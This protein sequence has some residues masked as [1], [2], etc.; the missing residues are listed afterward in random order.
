MGTYTKPIV[1]RTPPERSDRVKD[2]QWLM[3]GNNRFKIRTYFGAID[4]IAGP[5]TL[6]AAKTMK[7]KIGYP[8]SEL[9][10][11]F[12]QTL[13][14]YLRTDGN[15]KLRSA[16]MVTRAKARQVT[17][18]QR[19][20]P[21]T[22]YRRRIIGYPGQGTHSYSQPPH[23]WQ[24]DRAYDLAVPVG[25]PVVA[26]EAGR[27]GPRIGDLNSWNPRL[28]GKRLTVENSLNAIYYAHLSQLAVVA[29]QTVKVGQLLGYSGTANGVAHLHI[30]TRL[31]NPQA[32]L[33]GGTVI[34]SPIRALMA[35]SGSDVHR[36]DEEGVVDP[37]WTHGEVI[38]TEEGE[39]YDET[40]DFLML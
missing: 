13:Y 32:V 7:Y 17:R 14:D 9:F 6:S 29:Y 40:D 24:S 16:A 18:P 30:A 26:V 38:P 1:K 19:A 4:G 37:N 8:L 21:I 15:H 28:A 35:R 11:T 33:L 12:G 34:A 22:G 3:A 36:L 2:A 39:S 10:A 5:A 25:V 27:V 20:Y 31:G 23:N